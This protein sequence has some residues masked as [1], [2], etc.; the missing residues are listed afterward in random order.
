M[1]DPNG[2]P[3]GFCSQPS[4]G[5]NQCQLML[6]MEQVHAAEVSSEMLDGPVDL[7]GFAGGPLNGA[8]A[9][10]SHSPTYAASSNSFSG[11]VYNQGHSYTA[12]NTGRD[13]NEY[14][15]QQPSSC[16]AKFTSSRSA[17]NL[18]F[19]SFPAASEENMGNGNNFNGQLSH[20]SIP[21]SHINFQ[22]GNAFELR[23]PDGALAAR[24]ASLLKGTY[25]AVIPGLTNSTAS[26]VPGSLHKIWTGR[27]YNRQ[28][29]LDP[30]SRYSSSPII[31]SGQ[32]KYHN[33]GKQSLSRFSGQHMGL[34]NGYTEYSNTSSPAPYDT[35]ATNAASSASTE[36]PSPFN[37]FEPLESIIP[38]RLPMDFT[39]SNYTFPNLEANVCYSNQ[40]FRNF[41]VKDQDLGSKTAHDYPGNGQIMDSNQFLRGPVAQ[42][43][44]QSFAMRS[45]PTA[46][47]VELYDTAPHLT[48]QLLVS[49]AKEV[50]DYGLLLEHHATRLQP[51]A[52]LNCVQGAR[53]AWFP[54]G[55]Y[56]ATLEMP[57]TPENATLLKNGIRA[58]Q[59]A[60]R[61]S[62]L[63]KDF[64]T[65]LNVVPDQTLGIAVNSKHQGDGHVPDDQLFHSATTFD[66]MAHL[67]EEQR[68]GILNG[69][70]GTM[71]R[72]V[73]GELGVYN[74]SPIHTPVRGSGRGGG[75]GGRGGRGGTARGGSTVTKKKAAPKRKAETQDIEDGE[76][77]IMGADIGSSAT[78]PSA[79]KKTPAPRKRAPAVRK[80]KI[81]PAAELN[82]SPAAPGFANSSPVKP[83][84]LANV[85][86]LE[87]DAQGEFDDEYAQGFDF[88]KRLVPIYK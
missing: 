71:S 9:E 55:T 60:V 63:T 56:S 53:F 47:S 76:E 4:H 61:N 12:Y 13:R 15:M 84:Q 39:G 35:A 68:K 37:T 3:C 36:Q 88:E 81:E 86:D 41:E 6:D 79:T 72:S 48:L 19:S 34:G 31:G 78:K 87:Q 59:I 22:N 18:G 7:A 83:E 66:A 54:N 8:A 52:S 40:N 82:T 75:R 62:V 27:N 51:I 26:E 45:L 10:R 5:A 16:P 29:L 23:S 57:Q 58:G 46:P 69:S 17:S 14:S 85:I 44:I 43:S 42:K 67:L 70:I 64:G 74:D 2:D 32:A 65:L 28:T 21:S 11:N 73:A 24:R 33:H 20:P 80:I 77:V 25:T 50:Q 49:Y 30:A 1:S 38:K